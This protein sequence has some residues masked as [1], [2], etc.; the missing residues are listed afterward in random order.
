MK[1]MTSP[2]MVL[3]AGLLVMFGSAV[4]AQSSG[5][6]M[7]GSKM[8]GRTGLSSVDK[9]F[10]LKAEQSNL[11]EIKTS[12]AALQK[13]TDESYKT[14][15]QHMIDDHTT[16]ESDLKQLAQSK[17]VTLPGDPSAK[18]KAAATK[19]MQLNGPAFDG[20]Y[21]RIQRD[22]HLATIAL[23]KKE[24]KSGRDPDV[25]AYAEKYLPK[26]Q[27]HYKMLSTLKGAIRMHR[28]PRSGYS[29]H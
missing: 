24:I 2:L 16:A 25:K 10:M 5:N 17:G 23:F 20:S 29:L 28:R 12:Q 26:I 15:A 7:N 3:A 19:L 22:G 21:R 9:T 11:A 27:E 8:A 6:R 18:N 1:R 4:I 14:F 13:A